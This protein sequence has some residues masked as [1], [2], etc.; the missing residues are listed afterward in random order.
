[1]TQIKKP[2]ARRVGP[3]KIKRE[4][5]R[6]GNNVI[7]KDM[8]WPLPSSDLQQSLRYGSPTKKELLLAADIL[9]AYRQAIIDSQKKRNFVFKELKRHLMWKERLSDIVS[10]W[11]AN[12]VNSNKE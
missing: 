8:T 6:Q 3:K 2:I 11:E 7:F 4:S 1:M 12:F 10:D 9:S 5:E